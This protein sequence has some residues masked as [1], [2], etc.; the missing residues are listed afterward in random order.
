M[1]L[2]DIQLLKP[3]TS[4]IV[5]RWQS[6][7]N[8]T[9][10]PGAQNVIL[11]ALVTFEDT[12]LGG[13]SL[14]IEGVS[15]EDVKQATQYGF[16]LGGKHNQQLPGLDIRIFGGMGKG[17]PLANPKQQGLILAGTVYQSFANWQGVEMSLD[18]VIY[19]AKAFFQPPNLT[20]QWPA[21]TQ[22]APALAQTFTNAFPGYKQ[23]INVNPNRILSYTETGMYSSVDRFAS[24]IR[25]ITASQLSSNDPGVG[26]VVQSGSAFAIDGTA[27]KT[28]K[29]IS[30]F[31]LIGQPTWLDYAS[32]QV[33]TV[34]RGDILVGDVIQLPAGLTNT[35][36]AVVQTSQGLPG[37]R[38][39]SIFTGNFIVTQIRHLGNFRSGN[40]ADWCSIFNCVAA[41]AQAAG[42]PRQPGTG[43]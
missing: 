1:R 37:L 12:P 35:P 40:G 2:Y 41:P 3:G 9:F 24:F 6:F 16:H 25:R 27:P 43:G 13:S 18:M 31:D 42:A 22:L 21:G 39:A 8:G 17:L 10:D 4:T 38:Q 19:A 26:I 30:F 20:F 32:L 23:V 33:K 36:G 28:P 14:K 34:M 15:L 5:K 11:D 29:P 7:P